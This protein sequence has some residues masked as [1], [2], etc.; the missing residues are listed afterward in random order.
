M[1]KLN[2]YKKLSMI[3]AEINVSKTGFNSYGKYK[4][5]EIDIIYT[6]AKNLFM[7]YG[8][9]TTFSLEYSK[10]NEMYLGV[11]KVYDCDSD[12]VIST[13]IDSPTNEMKGS[14]ACQQVGSNVTYQCKYLYMS[15][16]ML[17]DGANDPDFK[18]KHE[19]SSKPVYNKNVDINQIPLNTNKQDSNGD[20][21]DFI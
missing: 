6:E 19:D 18:N 8:V 15:L 11:L 10:E 21:D 7:K 9:F 2:L 20:D 1:E 3:R 4:Y 12:C 16:L 17:D 13:R 14:S 5:Y